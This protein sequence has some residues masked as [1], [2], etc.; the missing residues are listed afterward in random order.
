M[1]KII[2]KNRADT[3]EIVAALKNGAV[4]VLPTDTVYGLVCDATNKKAVEK[5]YKIKQRP[6]SNFLPVFVRDI[7]MAKDL[8]VVSKE[9][10]KTTSK[11]WP[12][13]FTF[14]F[15]RVSRKKI[16]GVDKKTIALRIPKYR[17]LNNI[18]EKFNKPLA[19]T[20]ANISGQL[21]ST[22]IKD[23]VVSFK[24][25]KI[26]PDLIVDAGNLPKNKPSIIMDLTSNNIKIIRN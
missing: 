5:I 22:K 2:K 24:N 13:K 1:I 17:F 3:N 25:N 21:P 18:L 11:K 8:V 9:S 14:I 10:E 7:K 19:Q 16:Y 26:E 15:N 4:L 20:S 23:M 6:K 12:G